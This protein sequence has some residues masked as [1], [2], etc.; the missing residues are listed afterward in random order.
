MASLRSH[1]HA[2]QRRASPLSRYALL[3][4]SLLLIDASLYPFTGWRDVGIGAFAYLQGDWASRVLPFD[5]TVNALGYL[6]LG[7][8]A[9]LS[10]H[11]RLR[12][13]WLVLGATL[14]AAALSAGLEAIQTYLPSRVASKS[15][16]ASNVFG[17][18]AGA[19]LA[20]RLAH[21]LLD[22]GRLRAWRARWFAPDASRGLVLAMLWLGALVYPDALAFGTGGF[23]RAVD[24]DLADVAGR[25]FG[26]PGLDDPD[27]VAARFE[28]WEGIVSTLG[29]MGASL[30]FV[31]LVRTS[32]SRGLRTALTM[33]FLAVT[34]GWKIFAQAFLFDDLAAVPLA[35]PGARSG[36]VVGGAAV[37]C[38][39]FLPRRF[40]WALAIAALVGSIALVNLIPDN[41][42][43][44]AVAAAFTRGR[45]L[46]FY[47]LA[48]GLNL[49]WPFLAVAY[50][51][52]HRGPPPIS[53]D[54]ARTPM[55][56]SL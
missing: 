18:F 15:D 9:G 28:W 22:T 6:P 34:V 13:A 51:L 26:L 36:I 19:L 41:P 5:L 29:L 45:L 14:Y 12:G 30:L 27:G 31:N 35:I 40:R 20:A 52:R 43:A 37:L 47:G 33:A 7:V 4:Y 54:R 50:L 42:Y 16:L 2:W 48:R 21:P 38:A 25:W 17:A 39:S 53:P 8:F 23:L 44:N 49:A 24:P 11:P 3:A 46:N 55:S 32:V 56:R 1:G 10:F